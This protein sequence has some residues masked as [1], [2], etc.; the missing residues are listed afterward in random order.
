MIVR[1]SVWLA[2]GVG[3]LNIFL[4]VFRQRLTD[5][6]TDLDSRLDSSARA[7]FYRSIDSFLISTLFKLSKS[8]NV[9]ICIDQI[10]VLFS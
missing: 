6:F 1:L 10:T 9:Q 2:Q 7:I 5:I 4:S 3:D 8:K